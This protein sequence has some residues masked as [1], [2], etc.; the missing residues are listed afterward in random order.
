VHGTLTTDEVERRLEAWRRRDTRA[1]IAKPVML[2]EGLNLQQTNKAVFAGVSFKFSDVF[3][4]IHRVHRFGQT[5]RCDVRFVHAEA[6]RSVVATL[7]RKWRQHDITGARMSQ[8]VE[9]HGLDAAA[10]DAELRRSLG[11]ERIEAA[12]ERWRLVNNDTVP[13]TA[14]LPDASVGLIVTSIPFG[15]L[16][17]YS[18]AVED[19]G[20]SPDTGTFWRQ[21][22]YLT[23]ELLRVLEPGRVYCCHVKDRI[24]F[25][26]TTGAGYS[27][28]APFHAE[29]ILH[30]ISHGFDFLG[31]ITVVTDVVRENNQSYRLGW[32]EQC[33]DGSRMGV[34]TPEYVLLFRR[35]QTD[36]T[37]GYADRPVT[38][39]KEDYSRSRWQVDAHAF[40]RDRGNRPLTPDEFDELPTGARSKLFAAWSATAVYDYE[41]HVRIGERIDAKGQLPATFMCLAPSSWHPDVW[42]EDQV[43]RMRT[44]NTEQARRSLDQ[45]VCPMPF[46]IADRLIRRYS[47]PDDMVFDPFAGIGTV[48]RQAVLA[49][50]RAL[51]FELN[52]SYFADA[53]RYCAAADAKV[54]MPTLFD[55]E[56]RVS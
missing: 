47:N 53:V 12:G 20:H 15:T 13:E 40:W 16:Y 19:F 2:G 1:L 33:K 51:G 7:R 28:V 41:L 50:R 8:I 17:E 36:R 55:L 48:P 52:A 10:L 27:T 45:H 32:S 44:L 25:G 21:M 39:R 38:K 46:G 42:T 14:A 49:G 5:R 6:E 37:R 43:V 35:P 29:A 23:P 11:V 30:T 18:T 34:G 9:E 26:N 3:Q 4:A 24:T 31:Q 54:S 56:E 22:D